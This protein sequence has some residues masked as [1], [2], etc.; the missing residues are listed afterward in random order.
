MHN[1]QSIFEYTK[2]RDNSVS[3]AINKAE[4]FLFTTRSRPPSNP[5]GIVGLSP[6]GNRLESEACYVLLSD[7]EVQ[8]A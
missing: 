8:T 3:K 5:T 1:I 2:G 6:L 7:A 4:R